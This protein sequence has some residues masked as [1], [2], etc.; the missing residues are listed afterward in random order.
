MFFKKKVKP[1]LET[2][3]GELV[4]AN[5][6]LEEEKSANSLLLN[7]YN[8]VR[9]NY[10]SAKRTY[11]DA[12]AN[13]IKYG[14]GYAEADYDA[15]QRYRE[16]SNALEVAETNLTESDKRVKKA[17]KVCEKLRKQIEKRQGPQMGE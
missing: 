12:L 2:L 8:F 9:R 3:S 11:E 17:E 7:R 10:N 1:T 6:K 4:L 14:S 5:I 13:H 15:M 16:Q